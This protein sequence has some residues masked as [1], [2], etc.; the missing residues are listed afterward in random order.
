MLS[1]QIFGVS[2]KTREHLVMFRFPTCNP[3][4]LLK[5]AKTGGRNSPGFNMF[6]PQLR[7]LAKLWTFSFWS[8]VPPRAAVSRD[9]KHSPSFRQAL[10][11]LTTELPFG[12]NWTSKICGN[13]PFA[14]LPWKKQTYFSSSDIDSLQNQEA[15]KPPRCR[16]GR[17]RSD[18]VSERES[19]L[20]PPPLTHVCWP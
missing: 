19:S 9:T 12:R 15:E 3:K 16:G 7:G 2:G 5:L 18:L 20:F 1:R 11:C 14:F 17:G 6:E 13:L 8:L 4:P 10:C